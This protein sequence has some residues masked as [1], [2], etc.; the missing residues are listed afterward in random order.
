MDIYDWA[1]WTEMDIDDLKAAIEGGA[2]ITADRESIR[3]SGKNAVRYCNLR[4]F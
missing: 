1:D 3:F 2:S 4:V